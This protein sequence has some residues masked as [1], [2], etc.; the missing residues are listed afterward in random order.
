MRYAIMA[1]RVIVNGKWR[2][3]DNLIPTFYVDAGQ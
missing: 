1:T 2:S 3:I